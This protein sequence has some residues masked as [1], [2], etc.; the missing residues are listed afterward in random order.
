MCLAKTTYET[1]HRLHWYYKDGN[2]FNRN[3]SMMMVVKRD[4]GVMLRSE[5][6]IGRED[7]N[8]IFVDSF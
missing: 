1:N 3:N 7:P 5:H 2:I 4:K 8:F 6:S